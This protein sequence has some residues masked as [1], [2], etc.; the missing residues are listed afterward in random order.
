MWLTGAGIKR[1][2][3]H[4][5]TDD[6]SYNIVENPVHAIDLNATILHWLGIDHERLSFKFQGLDRR[7]HRGRETN[8]GPRNLSASC[9]ATSLRDTN[10]YGVASTS[11]AL[12]RMSRRDR[13]NNAADCFTLCP[14]PSWPARRSTR[15]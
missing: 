6:F 9:E 4:G 11:S 2:Y 15:A 1:G 14:P 8:R 12:F 10:P 3:V 5:E 13:S 7:P